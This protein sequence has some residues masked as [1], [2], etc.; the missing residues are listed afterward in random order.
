MYLIQ[1]LPTKSYYGISHKKTEKHSLVCFRK[2]IDA[3]HV[4]KSLGIYEERYN[5]YPLANNVHVSKKH[6][7]LEKKY[8]DLWIE[9]QIVH[10]N[11]I[12]Y[13]Y[14]HQLDLTVIDEIRWV[15]EEPKV[16]FRQVTKENNFEELLNTFEND[17]SII[18]E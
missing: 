3:E 13:L 7:I 1:H 14:S 17:N 15:N 4:Y 6:E 18:I 9:S 8:K 5:T 16:Y 11:F 2:K 10:Y 12:R